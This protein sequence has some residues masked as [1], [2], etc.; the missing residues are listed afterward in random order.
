MAPNLDM[1]TDYLIS[2]TGLTTAT[3]LSDMMG[4]R[5]SHD[6]I[7]RFLKN[8]YLDSSDLWLHSKP[9]VRE[10]ESGD[11]VLIVDDSIVEKAHTKPNAMVTWHW[12]HSKGRNVKG[13]NFVTLMYH[14]KD[15]S[16][17]VSVTLVEK[18]EGYIDKKTGKEKCKSPKTKNEHFR[19]MLTQANGKLLFLYV[20][21]DSWYSSAE[22]MN[23]VL[24][25][26]GKHFIMA[27][28]TTRTV[29]LSEDDRAAGRFQRVDAVAG[30]Q[31][32]TQLAAYIKG[33]EKQVLLVKQ[34]F[35]NK[36]ESQGV[37]YLVCSDTTLDFDGI[38]TIY[39]KR[40]KVE[41]YHKSLK[42]N[43]SLAKSPT[44]NISTQANHLYASM[45]AFIKLEKLK[46]RTG[47]GHFAIKRTLYEAAL[48]AM[49]NEF[50]LL[51][52]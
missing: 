25:F 48:R 19:E 26:E 42:Q 33:I 9:L 34:V 44:K 14:S 22:N 2:S 27:V 47:I 5:V 43:T 10:Y 3:G 30:L 39:K 29:A 6:S 17:P 7:T 16:V 8:S 4:N 31:N 12:D 51:C 37:L 38:T 15:M 1:Y 18:T 36:D 41:E 21:G 46:L 32:G 24:S 49:N 28:E 23:H 52:A 50:K 45:L 20:L 11:G 35:K 40:W 13:V